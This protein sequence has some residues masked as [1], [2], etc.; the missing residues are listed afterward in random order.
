MCPRGGD[1]PVH[2]KLRL[3]QTARELNSVSEACRREGYSRQQYYEIR[4]AFE[5]EG[6]EGLLDRP[7]GPRGPHPNRAT[8]EVEAAVLEYALRH[9]SEG[10]ERVAASLREAGIRVGAG[11][12]RG[13]WARHGLHTRR[14]RAARLKAEARSR[15]LVLDDEQLRALERLDPEFRDRHRVATRPGD[16]IV[17]AAITVPAPETVGRVYA[18]VVLDAFSRWVWGRLF[19]DRRPLSAVQVLARDVV[20]ALHAAGHRPTAVVTDGSPAYHGRPDRHPFASFLLLHGIEVDANPDDGFRARFR[21]I[22]LREYAGPDGPHPEAGSLEEMREAFEAWIEEYDRRRT[23][24]GAG[25]DGRT[26]EEVFR[27]GI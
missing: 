19:T 16:R 3:L 26:P 10:A 12:V 2:R 22:L 1:D 8:P 6:V 18:H 9:P 23:H 25:M 24:D 27:A 5:R 11:G 15:R 13:V 17:V 21:S 4:R 7:P 14:T 20:P